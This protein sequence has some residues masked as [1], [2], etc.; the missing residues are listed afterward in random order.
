MVSFFEQKRRIFKY[1]Y[2]REY[3]PKEK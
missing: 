3:I 2:F 1:F